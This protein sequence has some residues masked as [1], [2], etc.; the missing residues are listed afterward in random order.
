MQRSRRRPGDQRLSLEEPPPL[1][2]LRSF[3]AKLRDTCDGNTA[4]EYGLIAALIAS[5]LLIGV[6]SIGT[7]L[8][9]QFGNLASRMTG[10]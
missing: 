6:S 7:S 9:G 10:G 4:I 1:K 2:T 5:V 3:I 8:N